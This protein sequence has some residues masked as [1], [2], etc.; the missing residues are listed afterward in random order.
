MFVRHLKKN[1]NRNAPLTS[2][3]EDARERSSAHHVRSRPCSS[4]TVFSIPELYPEKYYEGQKH[5]F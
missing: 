5:Y 4:L 1:H 2:D 3:N